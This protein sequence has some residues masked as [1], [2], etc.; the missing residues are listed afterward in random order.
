MLKS[1]VSAYSLRSASA[2]TRVPRDHDARSDRFRFPP[3]DGLEMVTK[4]R[5]T[6][7]CHHAFCRG[8]PPMS[9]R[10]LENDHAK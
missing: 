2:G 4:R 9:E 7:F 3:S 1:T 10:V 8:V 5:G 6:A